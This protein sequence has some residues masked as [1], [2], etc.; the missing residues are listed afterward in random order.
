VDE[1]VAHRSAVDRRADV[2]AQVVEDVDL[3]V[4]EE[5]GEVPAGGPS[6]SSA[7]F[8]QLVDATQDVVG[9]DS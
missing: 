1:A 5:D 9:H 6:R 4:H 2:E 7:T 8:D 3:A